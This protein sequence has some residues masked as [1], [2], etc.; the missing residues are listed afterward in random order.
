[1]SRNTEF[2]QYKRCKKWFRRNNINLGRRTFANTLK[3]YSNIVSQQYKQEGIL[4]NALYIYILEY[5]KWYNSYLYIV[6]KVC[7]WY[8]IKKVQ[9]GIWKSSKGLTEPNVYFLDL[10]YIRLY[11]LVGFIHARI[12]YFICIILSQLECN[13]YNPAFKYQIAFVIFLLIK[14]TQKLRWFLA[15]TT[16]YLKSNLYLYK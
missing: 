9:R 5:L 7:C 3:A 11:T 13:C 16:T 14:F 12:T 2:T 6:I 4:L 1:M 15:K 8:F 10:I